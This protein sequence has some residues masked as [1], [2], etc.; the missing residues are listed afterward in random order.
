MDKF[1]ITLER[2]RTFVRVAERG[3]LTAVAKETGVAQ[4]SISRHL[5]E[6]ETALDASLLSRTTRSVRLT[7]EGARYYT[8]CIRILQLV[9]HASQ[10]LHEARDKP[11][12]TVR[13]SCSAAIGVRCFTRLACE[14]QDLY[15]GIKVELSLN[16][17]PI[18]LVREGFDISIRLGPLNDS[19]M[20][21]RSLGRSCRVL[22]ASPDYLA[23]R[24]TP[25]APQDL[26]QHEPIRMMNIAG[27]K[28]LT[29][30]DAN[31][32]RHEIPWDGGFVVDHGLAA[33]EAVA[34]GRGIVPAHMWL[35]ED[36]IA[37]GGL[38]VVLPDYVPPSVPLS[39]LMAPDRSQL[40]RVRLLANYIADRASRLPGVT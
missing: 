39:L 10:E 22:V 33:R 16:D 38:E 7:D 27:S 30:T 21:L 29:L 19:T 17:S 26:M 37:S 24:G 5:R 3:N 6:L 9:D 18:D 13:I 23:R 28:T 35:V 25:Q 15:P 8:Q 34:A 32:I 14:F 1:E 40:K 20:K 11:S 4:S 12:G 36:L 2:M 31:D